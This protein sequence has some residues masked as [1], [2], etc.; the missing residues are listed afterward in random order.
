MAELAKESGA[1]PEL[2]GEPGHHSEF[3][4]S[5]SMT[6]PRLG[7]LMRHLAAMGVFVEAGLDMY[8]CNGLTKTLSL[9]RYS[10]AW[11]AM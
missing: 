7:R 2:L 10:D 5:R 9:K 6:Y 11:P 4:I 3:A 1:E 8:A